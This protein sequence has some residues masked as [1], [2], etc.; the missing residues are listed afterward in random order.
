MLPCPSSPPLPTGA[1]GRC[2]AR[3]PKVPGTSGAMLMH[4]IMRASARALAMCAEPKT[5]WA[6]FATC[7]AARH[8]RRH[9]AATRG[10][11]WGASRARAAGDQH[12]SGCPRRVGG[13]FATSCCS[14]LGIGAPLPRT[15]PRPIRAPRRAPDALP[16]HHHH[17][18]L[19][20]SAGR[21]KRRGPYRR[22]SSLPTAGPTGQDRP[23]LPAPGMGDRS[24]AASAKPG[25]ANP[26]F[27]SHRAAPRIG[28]GRMLKATS[29][30]NGELRTE[31]AACGRKP[32]SHCR[33]ES[34]GWLWVLGT[35][36]KRNCR[37]PERYPAG[38]GPRERRRDA[39]RSL[40]SLPL[41][42]ATPRRMADGQSARAKRV[43]L[44]ACRQAHVRQM[45]YSAQCKIV[46]ERRP[47]GCAG[48]QTPPSAGFE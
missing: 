4:V 2:R 44:G 11:G 6:P 20:S 47:D 27:S 30:A 7:A 39:H 14:V 36:L 24:M 18:P 46:P 26:P 9:D 22:A 45:F 35:C 34:R 10:G 29:V 12:F 32:P 25:D 21:L 41:A 48:R 42:W 16:H 1:R 23:A 33:P 43:G 28:G 38:T 31:H 15:A 40:K 5:A 37:C 19:F 13:S 3:A 17:V 8:A